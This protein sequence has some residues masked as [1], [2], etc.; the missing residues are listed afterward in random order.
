MRSGFVGL[1]GPSNSGKSTFLNQVV[2]TKLSIVSPKPQ[3]TQRAIR[4]IVNR[5]GAQIIFVDTPGWQTRAELLSTA[6]N[7]VA[8]AHGK[9][10]DVLLWMFDASLPKVEGQI[11]KMAGLI[12]QWKPAERSICLL[13]KVD[14]VAKP[15]LL[16]LIEQAWKLGVFSEIVPLSA[17]KGDNVDRVLEVVEKHLPE[18]PALYPEGMITDRDEAFRIAELVREKIYQATREEIP[19]SVWVEVERE[20]EPETEQ[21]KKKVPVFLVRLHV[22][23]ASRKAILIGRKGA[24]LKEIG[25]RARRDVEKMLGRQVCLKIHVDVHAEWREDSRHVHRY[26]ELR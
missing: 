17:R 10:C 6:M 8:A 2:G 14:R 7:Q 21:G 19:Y 23:A 12:K 5:P 1:V 24:M 15:T 20:P 22:D 13:N 25:T 4:G 3:T 16:P 18:G 26:L 11:A 9:E